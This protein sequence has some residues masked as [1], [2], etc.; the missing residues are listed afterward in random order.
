MF[1]FLKIQY[2]LGKITKE[3]L[4][5]YVSTWISEFEYKKIIGEM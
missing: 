2:E 3:Q 5:S 1:D 4:Y